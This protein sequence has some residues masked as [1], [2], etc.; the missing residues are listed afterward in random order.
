MRRPIRP[1]KLA[2]NDNRFLFRGDFP[3]VTPTMVDKTLEAVV[4][5]SLFVVVNRP[6]AY[7]KSGSRF[8]SSHLCCNHSTNDPT[9]CCY[10]LLHDL[11]K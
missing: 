8:R 2:G 5:V 7:A 6:Y 11:K 3:K 10:I 9:C 4:Q 1:V